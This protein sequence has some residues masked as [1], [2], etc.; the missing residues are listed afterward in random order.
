MPGPSEAPRRARRAVHG[1][2]LLDKPAGLS[3]NQ[4]LQAVKRLYRASKAGHGGSLDPLATGLLPVCLGEAT[5]VSG[6]LLNAGK[7]YRFVARLGLV[8]RTG[9]TEG[10]VVAVYPVPA[11]SEA[12]V[13]AALERLRGERLQVPPMY[14]ALKRDGQPLYKLAR[15]GQEVERAPRPVTIHALELKAFDGNRFEAE[16]RCS[17]GTYIRTLAEEIGKALGCGGAHL[18][19]LR[20]TEVAPYD[21]TCMVTFEQLHEALAQG[22]ETALDALLLPVDTAIADWPKVELGG[23]AAHYL[24]SGQ[25]VR[26]AG[27]PPADRVRAYGPGGRFLGLAEIL[28]DGRVAPRRMLRMD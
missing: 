8:T 23:D 21:A 3:S 7:A 25:A 26:V 19:M 1:V 10:E 6:C 22:G 9:D 15:L 20:R 11:L 4:A 5:K 28:D 13:Q 27:G 14:S 12:D 18:T 16:V 2:L 24:A 17:K